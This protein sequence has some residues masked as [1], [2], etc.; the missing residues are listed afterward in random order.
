MLSSIQVLACDLCGAKPLTEPVI[1]YCPLGANFSEMWIKRYDF[2]SINSIKNFVGRMSGILFR[3]DCVQDYI[4]DVCVRF[5]EVDHAV[6]VRRDRVAY[7][8][9]VKYVQINHHQRSVM[10][11]YV[12][13][14][15]FVKQLNWDKTYMTWTNAITVLVIIRV[16]YK[17]STWWC[18]SENTDMYFPSHN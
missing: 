7:L 14:N 15:L 1:N 3:R 2:H 13:F 4:C 17:Y 5:P 12:T 11:N 10:I 16:N 9:W 6:N 8:P 18:F